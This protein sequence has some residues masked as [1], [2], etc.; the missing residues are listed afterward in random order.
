MGIVNT[1]GHLYMW[2]RNVWYS[3]TAGATT[4]TRNVI[5]E[6]TTPVRVLENVVFTTSHAMG[7]LMAITEG[8]HLYSW[9]NNW[10]GTLGNGQ[11][12]GYFATPSRILSNVV[13]ATFGGNHALAITAD[14]GLWTWGYN[15][16]G[17]LGNG[18]TAPNFWTNR[19]LR[20]TRVKENVV[21]A[22]ATRS[23]TAVV[24]N[25]GYAYR[26]GGDEADAW[27]NRTTIVNRPSRIHGI[28]NAVNVFGDHLNYLILTDNG[29]LSAWGF[30]PWTRLGMVIL[31]DPTT[32][33]DA[34]RHGFIMEPFR[35]L[36][37]GAVQVNGRNFAGRIG[38]LTEGGSL[39]AW[40][41]TFRAGFG[42][43][44]MPQPVLE[45]GFVTDDVVDFSM[46]S[47]TII[48]L[49]SDG[50]LDEITSFEE[51]HTVRQIATGVKM[52][53]GFLA[54]LNLTTASNW[55]HDGITQAHTHGLIPQNLQNNFTANAT[56]AEFAAFAVALYETVTGREITERATFNDTNDINVQK[57]GGLGV[58]GGVGNGNFNPGGTI[59]RQEA[60]VML[61]RLIAQ[62]DQPLPI[63]APT[64]ADNAQIASWATQSVGQ[65]QAAGIMGGV[66][67]NQFDPAGN[68]TREQS[69]ITMLRLFEEFN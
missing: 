3:S 67:N 68:F 2:G 41:A 55:A 10:N 64:F 51:R 28:T 52:P 54:R 50:S 48:V 56:R 34:E 40:G 9:G 27:G 22:A 1:Q 46:A 39:W 66:G 59:T 17:Q 31:A 29:D 42:N 61:S 53:A 14:G 69:V 30:N 45:P 4:L 62:I 8:G 7:K 23:G 18:T 38:V 35:V 43:N 24:T 21:A 12:S 60:A 49:R 13:Y 57:M 37:G 16:H 44:P 36:D 63:V 20:P 65:I 19:V 58:V 32:F 26:W 5:L 33:F 11:T 25:A 15:D 6:S 47:N